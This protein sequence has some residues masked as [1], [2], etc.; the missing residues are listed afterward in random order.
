ME[1]GTNSPHW[2]SGYLLTHALSR[3]LMDQHAGIPNDLLHWISKYDQ[4][5]SYLTK[6]NELQKQTAQFKI[7]LSILRTL[8]HTRLLMIPPGTFL[9]PS[10]ILA[11]KMAN[12]KRNRLKIGNNLRSNGQNRLRVS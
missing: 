3:K 5:V 11:A 1:I 10:S 6:Q 9:N 4:K 7:F 8:Q 2:N 12:P